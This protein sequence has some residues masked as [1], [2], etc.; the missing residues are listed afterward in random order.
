MKIYQGLLNIPMSVK[1]KGGMQA[2][3]KPWDYWNLMWSSSKV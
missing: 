1:A 3:T 2:H